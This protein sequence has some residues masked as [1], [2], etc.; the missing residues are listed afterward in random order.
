M[1]IR[2]SEDFKGH[3]NLPDEYEFDTISPFVQSAELEY[4]IPAIGQ[5]QYDALD[6]ALGSG[7]SA[8]Q[9]ALIKYARAAIAT[10]AFF[11][12]VPIGAV[13][14]TDTG[15]NIIENDQKKTAYK[16]Q[17][18][19]LQN[20]FKQRGYVALEGVLQFMEA[21]EGDY[22]LWVS[23]VQ[24]TKYKNHLIKTSAEF[25]NHAFINRSRIVFQALR[26]CLDQTVVER[27]VPIVC[28]EYYDELVSRQNSDSL[29]AADKAIISDLRYAMANFS[30]AEGLMSGVI[31]NHPDKGIQ[32]FGFRIPSNNSAE[33]IATATGTSAMV[34]SRLSK[35]EYHLNRVQKIMQASPDDYPTANDCGVI[36]SPEDN[37]APKF[38]NSSTNGIY[39]AY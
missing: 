2:E 29:M 1:L 19:A 31:E 11:Q 37:L 5:A 32:T 17:Q 14:I 10:L 28:Q 18:E 23:S 3:V 13:H 27:I 34:E 35:A 15:I 20:S 36:P 33:K 4:L 16:Y 38:D 9:T 6:I 7:P 25:G 24:Y 12:Y 22:P 21:H 8:Q 30:L 26:P 39:G